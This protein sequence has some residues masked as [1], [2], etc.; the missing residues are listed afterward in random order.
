VPKATKDALSN[1]RLR[2]VDSGRGLAL[3]EKVT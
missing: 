2:P 1:E 3:L